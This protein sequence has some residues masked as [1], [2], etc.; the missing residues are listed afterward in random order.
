MPTSRYT[1]RSG[2]RS[3]GGS[4]SYY[5]TRSSYGTRGGTSSGRGGWGGTS[6]TGGTGGTGWN[7]TGTGHSTSSY[8]PTQFTNVCNTMQQRMGS[9]RTLYTQCKGP[10][11]VTSFSPTTANKWIKFINSGALVYKFTNI[12]CARWFGSQFNH[13]TPSSAYRIMRQRFGSGIKAVT[14]G[15][16]N[17]W[18]VA[19]TQSVTA[20]QFS[21][22]SWK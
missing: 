10:G 1:S 13:T 20:R 6:S 19:A 3:G 17:C 4:S 12:E 14:R 21:N 18:L 2:R 22:Y 8:S 11:K 9:Y 16:G 15:K 7:R 5:G